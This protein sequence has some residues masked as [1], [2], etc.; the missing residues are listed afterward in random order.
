MELTDQNKQ[1]VK[2]MYE[3]MQAGE[4]GKDE[5]IGLFTEDAVFTEPFGG[6]PQTHTGID[7]IRARVNEMVQQPR[8][9]DF[10]LKIDQV[11]T[12]NGELVAYWTCTSAMM[13]GPMKGRDE[14][15]VSDGKILSLK[16]EL[17]AMPGASA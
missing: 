12:E 11:T 6:S 16:I 10:Q 15:K 14:L 8:P 4:S 3:A 17:T 5:L 9:P 13:P 1:I 7:A 2:Q